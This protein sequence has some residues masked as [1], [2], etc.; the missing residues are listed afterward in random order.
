VNYIPLPARQF[1]W[2]GLFTY[3]SGQLAVILALTKNKIKH[4]NVMRL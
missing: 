1:L 3:L 2:E 4:I